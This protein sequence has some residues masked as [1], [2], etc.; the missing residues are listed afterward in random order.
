M[1][2]L[3]ENFLDYLT[4]NFSVV[5]TGSNQV[6]LSGGA[7]PFCNADKKDLR[8]YISSQTGAGICFHCNTGFSPVSFVMEAEGCSRSQALNILNSNESAFLSKNQK[9]LH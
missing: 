2:N 4:E 9:K 5:K 1:R 7:C 3:T 6:K 8:L